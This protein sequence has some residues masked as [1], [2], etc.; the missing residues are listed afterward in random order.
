[1]QFISEG[2]NLFLSRR[3]RIE[4]DII[5]R[6]NRSLRGKGQIAVL[7]GQEVHP[8]E[9]LGSGESSSGFRIIDL[10]YLLS[11][12]AQDVQKYLKRN[13]GQRIY[14]GELLAYKKANLFGSDKVVTA[15]TDGLLDF[16]N[17]KT[18]EIR[19]SLFPKKIDLPS[20]VYGVVEDIDHDRGIV[21]IR[22]QVSRVHGI[23]GTGRLRDGALQIVGTKVGFIDK[24]QITLRAGEH[25]LL[26][27]SLLYKDAISQAISL[28]VSGIITGGI[29]AKD[30]KG[31]AGGRL[32]FP[33]KIDNDVGISIVVC[34]GFGSVPIGDDI[35]SL[36]LE[37]SDK[38]VLMDGNKAI[39]NLPTFDSNCLK[40]IKSTNLPPLNDNE[41]VYLPQKQEEIAISKMV[42]VVGTSFM[43]EQG[44]II[45]IDRMDS[46][47]P[48]KV[49]STL[50]TLETKRRKIRIPISNLEII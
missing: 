43:G 24:G 13:L 19:M 15:P 38:F 41:N 14:K 29:N 8:E 22:T 3:L 2:K 10:A 31:M 40:R 1:M 6:I 25:I 45:A 18:G 11:V 27:G 49:T 48:S 37:Y 30:Y 7:K 44:K 33:K 42:R 21:V 47:L 20:G 5:T 16:L 34:E 50:V 36:L 26:G 35:Y 23:F 12:S 46:L 28:G 9:I 17:P 39:I 32:T 4:K